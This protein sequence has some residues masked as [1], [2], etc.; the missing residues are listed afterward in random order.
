MVYDRQIKGSIFRWAVPVPDDQTLLDE[1]L[2]LGWIRVEGGMDG[3]Y[4][5]WSHALGTPQHP[6]G[7]GGVGQA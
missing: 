3:P 4:L 6:V 5:R 7:E 2:R 1:Y